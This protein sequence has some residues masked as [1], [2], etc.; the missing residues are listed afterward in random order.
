[1]KTK[2]LIQSLAI[3]S[4]ATFA[5]F[6]SWAESKELRVGTWLSPNHTMNAD[7][8]PTWGKWI[9]QAT[10]GRVTVKIEYNMGHPKSLVDLVE[11]GAVDAAWTFHGYIPGRFQL[12][13]MVELPGVKAGAEAVS[14]AHWRINQEYFA[15][16]GENDGV[17]LAAL[18]VH[19][20]GHIHLREPVDSLESVK[21]LKI[22][23]GGGVSVEI[24]KRL[25]VTGVNAPAT[26]AY[27]LLAQGVA[28]GI[29]MQMDYMRV[30]RYKEVAPYTIKMPHGMYLGSFG[31]FLSPDFMA[32]LSEQDQAAIRRVSGEK[33][34][35]LA[36]R[37]WATAD[38]IGEADIRATGSTVVEA[39]E[40]DIAYFE[41]ITEGMDEE[42]I[43]KASRRGVDAK[44]AL[45]AFRDEAENYQPIDL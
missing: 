4:V 36:G 45:K 20:P 19:G 16:S 15:D 11:D 12:P 14:V 42:W 44:S 40:A 8:I 13:Q 33:L 7:V 35:A 31:M 38:D 17:E 6:N 2:S 9:E 32:G 26:K 3:A 27:E 41:K 10:D 37:A 22:R 30:G 29:F 39:T 28:D 18:F 5:S 21:G 1:M 23:I 34:S 43:H 25:G 24:G